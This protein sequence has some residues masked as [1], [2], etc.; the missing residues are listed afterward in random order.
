MFL[1]FWKLEIWLI[2]NPATVNVTHILSNAQFIHCAINHHATSQILFLTMVYGSN[3]PKIREDLWTAL[4]SIQHSVTSWVLLGDFN[5]IRDVSEKISPTPPNLDDILAFNTCLLN[6]RLDDMRGPGCEY[7]WTNKQDD[8]T[9]TWSKLDMALANPDWFN[10]FPTTYAN[11]LPAGISDHSPVLVTVFDDPPLKSRFSFLNCWTTH[12]S[13]RDLVTQA[14]HLPVQGTAMFKLFGKLKNVRVSLYGLHKQ[15]YSDI[16]NKVVV[17]KAALMDCQAM[18]QSCPLSPDLIHKEKQ[19]LV[20]YNTLKQAEVSFLKQKAKVDNIKHG[21]FSSKYFFSRPQERKNQQIIGRIVDRHGTERTGLSD[22]AE[23]FV[24]YYSHLLGSTTP[25]SPLDTSLIHQGSCVSPEDSASLIQPVSL[26]EIKAALFSI[27]SDKSPGP[28][29]FS[30]GFFKD[31]WELISSDF[32]KA[33][34][35]FFNTGK[36]SKQANSTLLTLIPKKKISNSD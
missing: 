21:D 7:T 19:L 24:D 17:A 11:F 1:V 18:L 13:Y 36:M 31:S 12:A 22:V 20:D 29:G 14:W 10:Q 25:T 35:N 23:G 6:C 3:D 33:V 28:D 8:S 2:F 4:S 26:D 34:L 5:V 15:N 30:S 27:G 16:P 32:C 9:R